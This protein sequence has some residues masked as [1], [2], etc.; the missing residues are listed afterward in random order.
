MSRTLLGRLGVALLLL[1]SASPAFAQSAGSI[2]GT[3]TDTSGAIVPG[4]AVILTSESTKF[5]RQATTDSTGSYYFASVDVGNYTL[6][7]EIS[8]FKTR[9][10]KGVRL[11]ANDTIGVDVKL[12]IGQQTETIVVT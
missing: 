7:V 2:R 11:S 10:I 6:K 5:A 8:G 9:E 4:A 1:A 12:E 3:V